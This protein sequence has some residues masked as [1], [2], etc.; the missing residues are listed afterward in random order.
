MFAPAQPGL[1]AV[2]AGLAGGGSPIGNMSQMLPLIQL[3]KGQ[4]PGRPAMSQQNP[5]EMI[6]RAL[7]GS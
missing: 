7:G 6:L 2:L 4:A 1:Q 3:L 5:Q